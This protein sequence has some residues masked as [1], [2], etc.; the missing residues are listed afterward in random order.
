MYPVLFLI[1]QASCGRGTYEL[2]VNSGPKGLRLFFDQSDF[3][4]DD[5]FSTLEKDN[6]V[7]YVEDGWT[8]LNA[9]SYGVGWLGAFGI[10]PFFAKAATICALRLALA[11]TGMLFGFIYNMCYRPWLCLINPIAAIVGIIAFT[12]LTTIQSLLG[13]ASYS[14]TSAIWLGCILL[15]MFCC[16][17]LTEGFLSQL[18]A[19]YK[20]LD[21]ITPDWLKP[22]L[23]MVF[24]WGPGGVNG[25]ANGGLAVKGT[26]NLVLTGNAE[27]ASVAFEFV[28]GFL[29]SGIN[30]ANCVNQVIPMQP[31]QVAAS[32]EA[33]NADVIADSQAQ[34]ELVGDAEFRSANAHK[35]W[36]LRKEKI[37]G[38]KSVYE[39][40]GEQGNKIASSPSCQSMLFTLQRSIN[41]SNGTHSP[42][43]SAHTFVH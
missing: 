8:D 3:I 38:P 28:L 29:S 32:L 16:T 39:M 21:H 37:Y 31:D 13:L 42:V 41:Q 11:G 18:D 22:M 24:L 19:L 15:D 6:Q 2:M 14:F 17:Q 5:D 33:G 36:E 7:A 26:V 9:V 1:M 25:L 23:A 10:Y 20:W 12:A 35:T 34:N 4:M 40:M 30:S 27:L 43:S